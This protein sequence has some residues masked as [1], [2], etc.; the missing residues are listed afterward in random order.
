MVKYPNQFP[1]Q[2]V[3]PLGLSVVLLFLQIPSIRSNGSDA[4]PW[5]A[6][7]T[8]GLLR[9]SQ[10]MQNLSESYSRLQAG[11]PLLESL[12]PLLEL[13]NNYLSE[14]NIQQL[15]WKELRLDK[16]SQKYPE[17]KENTLHEIDFTIKRGEVVAIAGESGSG[18]STL[19]SI[20]VGLVSPE[21]EEY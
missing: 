11:I 9:L 14:K 17:N 20:I 15:Q 10:P 19:S 13:P 16:I 2:L 6:L 7:V 5:L 18:K 1:R 12:L 21:E 4:L 3:E 8:L